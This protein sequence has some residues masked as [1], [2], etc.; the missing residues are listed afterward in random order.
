MIAPVQYLWIV[1]MTLGNGACWVEI[2]E[3]EREAPGEEVVEAAEGAG[4]SNAV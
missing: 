1:C 4:A 2:S 3:A